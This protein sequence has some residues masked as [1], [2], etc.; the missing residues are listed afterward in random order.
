MYKMHREYSNYMTQLYSPIKYD[1]DKHYEKQPYPVE[2][3]I[4]C[5]K[6]EF[7]TVSYKGL[8]A[9]IPWEVFIQ[10]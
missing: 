9:R 1:L 5:D 2:P 10:P 4:N 3:F 8:S 6:K 7:A